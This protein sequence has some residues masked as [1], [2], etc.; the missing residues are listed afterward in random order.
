MTLFSKSLAHGG[1]A[2]IFNVGPST[3]RI[4]QQYHTELYPEDTAMTKGLFSQQ[5]FLVKW[6]DILS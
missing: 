2:D 6:K 3:N 1:K 4:H 5:H